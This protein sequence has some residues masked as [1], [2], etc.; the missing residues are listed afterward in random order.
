MELKYLIIL[1]A[2]SIA[3][4]RAD[5]RIVFQHQTDFVPRN[6]VDLEPETITPT[7]TPITTT[8][9]TTSTTT[10]IP[11]TTEE[12]TSGSRT[13]LCPGSED[14]CDFPSNYPNQAILKAALRQ[15]NTLG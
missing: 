9:I 4:A 12:L 11:T 5:A 13:Q 14:W 15:N 1:L 8:T 3:T 2:S 10:I 7:T 6:H